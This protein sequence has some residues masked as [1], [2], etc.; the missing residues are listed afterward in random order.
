MGTL[1]GH[2]VYSIDETRNIELPHPSFRTKRYASEEVRYA[3]QAFISICYPATSSFYMAQNNN[4]YRNIFFSLD[5]RNQVSIPTFSLWHFFLW[6][7]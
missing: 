4:R 3:V 2:F 1:G 7:E 5:V 6:G